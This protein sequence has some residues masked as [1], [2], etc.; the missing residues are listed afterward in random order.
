MSDVFKEGTLLIVVDRNGVQLFSLPLGG[1]S[2][3]SQAWEEVYKTIME[4]L[5]VE[6]YKPVEGWAEPAKPLGE[7]LKPGVYESDYGNAISWD[8]QTAFD[9]DMGEEVPFSVILKDRY[10]RPLD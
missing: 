2:D 6:A 4:G 9:L 3:R 10:I 1:L 7:A 8:G 5:P